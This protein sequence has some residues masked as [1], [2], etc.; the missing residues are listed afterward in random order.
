MLCAT[1][2]P[3][4]S[5]IAGLHE[6]RAVAA[7]IATAGA[8]GPA[9]KLSRCQPAGMLSSDGASSRI[10]QPEQGAGN[11]CSLKDNCCALAGRPPAAAA[12][13]L[14]PAAAGAA[15]PVPSEAL[16]RSINN[17][18]QE[19]RVSSML[20]GRKTRQLHRE[21]WFAVGGRPA[22]AGCTH[23]GDEASEHLNRAQPGPGLCR[24]LCM[25]SWVLMALQSA[26]CCA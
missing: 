18:K 15:L 9:P 11:I 14:H 17:A 8:A 6:T 16:W 19:D 26:G 13:V 2:A 21:V 7:A 20:Q 24:G 22:A 12:A 5:L 4:R 1:V 3:G 10:L 23:Q 25:G